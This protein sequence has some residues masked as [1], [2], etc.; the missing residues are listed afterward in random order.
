M[1][2][3]G[4]HRLIFM[5]LWNNFMGSIAVE[6]SSC[7]NVAFKIQDTE[8]EPFPKLHTSSLTL[9]ISHPWLSLLHYVHTLEGFY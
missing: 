5:P 8:D 3:N 2:R 7:S 6:H 4:K 9:V 1:S